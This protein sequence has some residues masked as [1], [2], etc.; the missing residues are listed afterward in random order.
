[1]LKAKDFRSFLRSFKKEKSILEVLH[2]SELDRRRG[3]CRI[4]FKEKYDNGNFE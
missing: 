1:M 3:I 4:L 2:I